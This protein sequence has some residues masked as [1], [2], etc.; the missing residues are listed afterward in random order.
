VVC[1][2]PQQQS[3]MPCMQLDRLQYHLQS[4]EYSKSLLEADL[5]QRD[6]YGSKRPRQS[7]TA[8]QHQLHTPQPIFSKLTSILAHFRHKEWHAW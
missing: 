2:V 4:L 3:I 1:L 6:L 8:C 7:T 5:G